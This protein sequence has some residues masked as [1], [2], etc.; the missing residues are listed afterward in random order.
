M[1]SLVETDMDALITPNMGTELISINAV[2]I[3][4][5]CLL[6]RREIRCSQHS[7][8][9]CVTVKAVLALSY[10]HVEAWIVVT[11]LIASIAR[12]ALATNFAHHPTH[13]A[14]AQRESI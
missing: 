13:I 3:G 1:I 7:N 8:Q 6:S 12:D 4:G 10:M 9:R 14:L 5:S 11:Q 2:A